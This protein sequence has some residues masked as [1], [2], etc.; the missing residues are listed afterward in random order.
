MQKKMERQ[1]LVLFFSFFSS[2]SRMQAQKA[3]GRSNRVLGGSIM[4]GV[5]PCSDHSFMASSSGQAGSL[6]QQ[7]QGNPDS[8]L[9]QS[10]PVIPQ[11]QQHQHN[12]SVTTLNSSLGGSK[13]NGSMRPLAQ[14]YKA[15]NNE[16]EVINAL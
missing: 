15:A 9:N 13:L 10:C 1:F 8:I 5:T 11:S 2:F 16:H 12:T 7:Q 3:L 6:E 14:A 4:I